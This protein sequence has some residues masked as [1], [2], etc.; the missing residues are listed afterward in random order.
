MNQKEHLLRE[1]TARLIQAAWGTDVR[2]R[3][4]VKNQTYQ[5][6]LTHMRSRVTQAPFPDSAM[7]VLGGLLIIAGV[8]ILGRIIGMHVSSDSNLALPVI[9]VLLLLNLVMVPVGSFVIIKRRRYG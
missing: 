7:C 4:H 8:W 5:L 1:N 2:L 9:T 6:I 3:S